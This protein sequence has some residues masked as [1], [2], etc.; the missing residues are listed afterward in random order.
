MARVEGARRLIHAGKTVGG[1]GL[2]SLAL[3]IAMM[4]IDPW[5]PLTPNMPWHLINALHDLFGLLAALAVTLG[6][7]LWFAGWVIAG[8]LES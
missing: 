2:G 1:I 4:L 6:S 7:T 3:W 8:F 5:I